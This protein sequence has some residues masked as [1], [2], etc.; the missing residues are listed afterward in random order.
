MLLASFWFARGGSVS[1]DLVI[2]LVALLV[3]TCATLLLFRSVGLPGLL[4]RP[5]AAESF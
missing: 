3:Q 5:L 4:R 1:V 2:L